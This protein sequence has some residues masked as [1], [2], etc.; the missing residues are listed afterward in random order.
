MSEIKCIVLYESI[1]NNNTL[2]VA[3]AIS[4]TLGCR[5][6]K[7]SEAMEEDLTKYETI[8]LGSGI[9]FGNLHPSI[10]NIAK[11]FDNSP[12]RV[13]IFSTRGNPIHGKYHGQL[14]EILNTKGKRIVGEISFK[15][16]DGTGPFLIF[17]GGNI[18]RPNERDLSQSISF[19]RKALPEYCIKDYYKLLDNRLP[20]IDGSTNKYYYKDGKNLFLLRGDIVSINQNLCTGCG[21]CKTVCPMGVIELIDKKAIPDKELD[22]TLCNLCCINCKERAITLHYNWR[23]TINVAKRHKNKKSL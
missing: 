21:R 5:L 13:F 11:N 3:K 9:Y 22:C 16:Y 1:Y 8:G 19:I 18:G 23:D 17:G 14:K 15:G 20:V 4:H 10:I 7:A 2:K 12:Q 6:I